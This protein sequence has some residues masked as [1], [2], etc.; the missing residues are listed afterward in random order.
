MYIFKCS[1]SD[2]YYLFCDVQLVDQLFY[3]IIGKLLLLYS[4]SLLQNG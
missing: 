2:Y 1:Y 4:Y 3:M